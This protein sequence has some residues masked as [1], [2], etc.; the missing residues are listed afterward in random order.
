MPY[1]TLGDFVLIAH[2]AFVVF[3]VFGALMVLKWPRLAW[4]HIPSALW[5]AVVECAGWLCPLTP[6]EHWLRVKAGMSVE[7]LG[8]VEQYLLP[9]LYPTPLTRPI[10]ITLG[11]IVLG[12][13]GLIY[14]WVL[15]RYFKNRGEPVSF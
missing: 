15:W 5:A 10:Q 1:R 3:V 11:A 14:T 8:F 4:I 7:K 6:L 12:V 13:N 9:L 2:F